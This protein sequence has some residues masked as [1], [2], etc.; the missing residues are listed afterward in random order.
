MMFRDRSM[1][2]SFSHYG[3]EILETVYLLWTQTVRASAKSMG[4]FDLTAA[5]LLG[6]T[7]EPSIRFGTF[8]LK[9]RKL[10]KRDS[11]HPG[12]S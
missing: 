5:K 3:T 8:R 2:S 1:A 9:I 10:V 7:T 12:A 11:F 4:Q 6:Q